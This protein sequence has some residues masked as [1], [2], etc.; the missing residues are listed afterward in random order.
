MARGVAISLPTRVPDIRKG[1]T[2]VVLTGRDAGKR[3]TVDRVMRRRKTAYGRGPRLTP[4][5]PALSDAA[6]LVDGIN[7]AKRHQ[8]PR[9]RANQNDRV[10]QVQQGGILDIQLPMPIAK[11][12][13]VCPRCDQPTRVRHQSLENGQRVRQ[14][15]KCNE[16][17]EA[18]A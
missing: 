7:M 17:I 8:K 11:V 15:R 12:M 2:I 5:A 14:C 1:D 4:D 10:P 6:V 13:L 3:G 18:R 9:P 16:Q